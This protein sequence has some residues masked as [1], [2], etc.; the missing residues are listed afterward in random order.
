MK[1][2]GPHVNQFD[3]GAAV[4]VPA[5]LLPGLPAPARDGG[6]PEGRAGPPRRRRSRPRELLASAS[7]P[8]APS[9]TA[10]SSTTTGRVTAARPPRRRRTSRVGVHGRASREA[11]NA[12]GLSPSEL[13]ARDR[14]A[15]ATARPSATNALHHPHRRAHR[16]AH[17]PRPRGRALHRPH[18]AEGRRASTRT[19]STTSS[20]HDKA[21]PG[22]CRA[23]CIRGLERARRPQG[24]GRRRRSNDDEVRG[25][26]ARARRA[27]AAR[28][29][30]SASSGRS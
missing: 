29:S 17:D 8:A 22:S 11:A 14:A 2:A 24:R 23:R 1:D 13:L 25:A 7:T 21:D 30:R 20:L 9:P 5:V 16:A 4:R 28:R 27:R 18:Q 12:L 10:S 3:V 15:S 6:L 26:R 19:R